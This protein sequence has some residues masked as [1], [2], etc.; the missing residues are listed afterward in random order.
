MNKV[1]TYFD[2]ISVKD[3]QSQLEMIVHWKRSWAKQ[4]WDVGVINKETARKHPFFWEFHQRVDALPTVNPKDYELSCYYRWLAM[5]VVGGGFMSD[6][7]VVNY[8]FTPRNPPGDLV[9]YESNWDTGQ[10]TPSVVGGTQYGFMNAC[11]A[12]ALSD[13]KDIMGEYQG[14]DHTSDMIAMQ[15][16][17]GKNIYVD[18]PIVAQYGAENWQEADLVHYAHSVTH[19]T[20]RVACM[21]T[22]RPI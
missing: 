7:D 16:V 6:Y 9:I 21:R 17:A 12:F 5:A 18:P 1:Y 8:G 19:N 15:R 11:M 20:D 13:P 22:A 10:I 3:V 14:R 2:P 4:G